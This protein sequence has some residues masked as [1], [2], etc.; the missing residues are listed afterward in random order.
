MADMFA[1]TM[2]VKHTLV[3]AVACNA[4]ILKNMARN[5]RNMYECLI[6]LYLKRFYSYVNYNTTKIHNE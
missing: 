4:L 3:M 6:C 5:A 1:H 2:L